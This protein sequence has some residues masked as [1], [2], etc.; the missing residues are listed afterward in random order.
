[1]LIVLKANI[2]SYITRLHVYGYNIYSSSPQN[3]RLGGI[4]KA[5]HNNNSRIQ[6]DFP[7]KK[8]CQVEV[9]QSSYKRKNDKSVIHYYNH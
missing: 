4:L 9:S 1:M 8:N 7:I 2:T 5:V 3:E 6:V